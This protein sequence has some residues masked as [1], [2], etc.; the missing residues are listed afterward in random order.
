MKIQR[1]ASI[2]RIHLSEEEAV[3]GEKK[4]SDVYEWI[5]SIKEIDVSGV[6][7]IY[8]INE[9]ECRTVRQVE[10]PEFY[11]PNV[12]LANT[13]KKDENFILVPKVIE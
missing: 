11:S 9:N 1:I 12:I 4:L 7:P 13:P 8:N 2:A 3:L 5:Q 6:E 10:N